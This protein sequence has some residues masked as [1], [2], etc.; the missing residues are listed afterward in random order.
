MRGF[1]VLLLDGWIY[2]ASSE[3]PVV[4]FLP[5][6]LCRYG[7]FWNCTPMMWLG[8]RLGSFLF[9][10]LGGRIAYSILDLF[11]EEELS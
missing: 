1:T 5:N 8:L 3:N 6:K 2:L 7:A 11:H 10:I 4:G 9:F